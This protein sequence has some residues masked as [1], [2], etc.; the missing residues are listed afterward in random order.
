V[1]GAVF[2]LAK[3]RFA[4]EDYSNAV[5]LLRLAK[6]AMEGSAEWHELMG[7]SLYRL[8]DLAQAATE[9]QNAMDKAPHDENYVL[10]LAEVFTASN[11]E[12]AAL[13]LLLPGLKVFPK[14]ARMWF[15]AGTVYLANNDLAHA[16]DAL[17][18]SI[19]LDPKLDLGYQVLGHGYRDAGLWDKLAETANALIRVNPANHFGYF[20]RALVL[21]RAGHPE[22]NEVEAL[23]R[24][25]I[26]LEGA[27]PEPRYELAKLLL[28]KGE[29]A[30]SA[31]ELEALVK[32]SPDFGP[33]Y[34]RLYQL[35]KNR[36]DLQ[37]SKEALVAYQQLR[38]RRGLPVR[39]LI[40][41]VRQP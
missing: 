18:R 1:R 22:A 2:D 28:Q 8:G 11:N 7:Y 17:R 19:E 32:V 38:A 23:L 40:V 3:Q 16:E 4:K 35:Y 37:D 12:Q 29:T 21:V 14:S 27:D 31:L 5:A 30:K 20:Y 33:A 10:E 24:K 34:Y 25:S 36:G 26:A 15:A 13:A 41:K 39:Q 9:L 6:P